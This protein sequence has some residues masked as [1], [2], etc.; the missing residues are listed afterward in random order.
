M[1]RHVIQYEVGF[2]TM[3]PADVGLFPNGE[4]TIWSINKLIEEGRNAA[5]DDGLTNASEADAINYGLLSAA[6]QNPA[7]GIETGVEVIIHNALFDVSRQ[8]TECSPALIND[9][10]NRFMYLLRKHLDDDLSKF[11]SWLAGDHSNL[12]RAIALS[13]K[14]RGEAALPRGEV[15]SALQYLGWQGCMAVAEC[16]EWFADRFAQALPRPLSL[17]ERRLFEAMYYRQAYFGG[18]SLPLIMARA[19][20]FR[21][22]VTKLWDNP[23]D[24][25]LIGALH[26][27]LDWYAQMV[28][29]KRAVERHKKTRRPRSIATSANDSTT[30][31][32]RELL[33]QLIEHRSIR[34]SHCNCTPQGQ[35][36]GRTPSE[37]RV[38]VVHV[39]CPEHGHLET[40]EISDY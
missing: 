15:K 23:F 17:D 3:L 34:C 2:A 25:H 19:D 22:V 7:T 6:M 4:G 14:L 38:V 40:F 31:S 13:R 35:I 16:V 32:S 33:A 11:D 26:R 28:A 1:I 8:V 12:P 18:L 30:Q 10:W 24:E 27:V 9:V 29:A 5:R 37:D 39:N 20:Q 21:P 36:A